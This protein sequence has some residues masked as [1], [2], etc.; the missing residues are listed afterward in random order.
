MVLIFGNYTEVSIL[1][2]CRINGAI[3]IRD[4]AA[5]KEH[6][7]AYKQGNLNIP[8]HCGLIN[9]STVVLFVIY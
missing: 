5:H 1:G 7:C 8:L 2:G 4:L 3:H 6:F 9:V